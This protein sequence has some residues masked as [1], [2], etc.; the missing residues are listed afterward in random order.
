MAE[1]TRKEAMELAAE[2]GHAMER[3]CLIGA[4]A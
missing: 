3:D 4:A 1:V 2:R